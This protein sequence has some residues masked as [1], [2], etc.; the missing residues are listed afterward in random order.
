[1][2]QYLRSLLGWPAEEQL[3]DGQ[4]LER[5]VRYRDDSAFA[6]LVR[7]YGPLVL[8]VCERV[9]TDAQDAEDAFQAT[10]LVLVRKADVLDRRGSL[11]NWLYAVANRTALK[12]RA[13]AAR[14]RAREREAEE[15]LAAQTRAEAGWQDLRAVLDEELGQLP[16]KYRVPLVLCCLEGKTHIQAARELGWPS[17]T[18][19]RRIE[20][21]RE[22]LRERLNRRGV[23]LSSALL[24]L[25]LTTRA[26]AAMVSAELMEATI[27][28]ASAYGS[29]TALAAGAGSVPAICLAEEVLQAGGA[30][31]LK[32]VGAGLLGVALLGVIGT[33][34]SYIAHEVRSMVM[35]PRT[36]GSCASGSH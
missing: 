9:L 23:V 4:L 13:N 34:F 28:T 20:R 7:R 14:R 26:K 27:A 15:M 19:S 32:L 31:K 12:A 1:M 17:G 16:E 2:R 18:M 36:G 8:G 30:G 5:Y 11:G 29:G 33:S 6:A 10:F 35:G 25:L 3:S 22:M 24:L 21:G